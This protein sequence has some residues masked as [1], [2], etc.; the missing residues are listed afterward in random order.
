[1][2]ALALAVPFISVQFV[3]PNKTN[4]PVSQT[5]AIESHARVTP[6]VAAIF[7]RACKD[8]HSNETKWPW[9]ARI[10]PVS[11]YVADHVEHGRA[12]MNFSEWAAYDREQADWLLGAMCMTAERG[13]MPLPSYT[14]MHPAAKLSRADVQTLCAWSRDELSRN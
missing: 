9:Y 7:E 12:E 1:M 13:R 3:R 8:C 6:E 5:R 14:R 4:L 11:W 2:A 10:A